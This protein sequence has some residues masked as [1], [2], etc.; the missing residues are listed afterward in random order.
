M[1]ADTWLRAEREEKT[2]ELARRK[3][4]E[5]RQSLWS[6]KDP[7]GDVDG[8]HLAQLVTH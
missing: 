6:S 3:Q 5:M 8:P 1:S 2:K 4:W 7:T